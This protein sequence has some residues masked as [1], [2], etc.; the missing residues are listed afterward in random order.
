MNLDE[1]RK[2][3]SKIDKDLISLIAQRQN[4]VAEIGEYKINTGTQGL[5]QLLADF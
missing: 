3:L 1:L 2:R 5:K 4:V